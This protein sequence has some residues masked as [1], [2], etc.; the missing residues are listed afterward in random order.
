LFKARLFV[1]ANV[2]V[3]GPTEALPPVAVLVA[4]P[5]VAEELLVEFAALLEAEVA[6]LVLVGVVVVGKVSHSNVSPL[7]T[8][9]WPEPSPVPLPTVPVGT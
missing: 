4:L 2:L 9:T 3:I 5:P 7:S 6:L 8:T 1:F